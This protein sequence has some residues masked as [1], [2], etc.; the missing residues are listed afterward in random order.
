[1]SD[2]DSVND[3][4]VNDS[5][6]ASG[7]DDMDSAFDSEEETAPREKMFSDDEEDSDT[8]EKLTAANIE[9]LSKKLDLA[10]AEEEEQARLELE[11][12]AMQTNIAGDALDVFEGGEK[13]TGLA[14][15][16]KLLRTR[17]NETIRILED[18]KTLGQPGKSRADYLSLLLNDF[19]TYYG[20]TPY[21]AEKLLN[22]FT[23]REA[24][25][26]FEANET[27]R[28]AVIRTNT[29]RTNRRTLAQA[30]INRGVV[31]EPVGKWSKVGLQVFE[32]AVP[33]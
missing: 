3:S 13:V 19:C 30:L 1:M 32:S 27:P 28:P 18:L 6:E 10:A 4:D 16:L 15:D 20:Y 5:D 33:L 23:P 24:F 26:F 29:L 31:L 9:G 2:H 12:S 14:P 17:I 25:A 7:S 22:L 11:E 8:E 21:L